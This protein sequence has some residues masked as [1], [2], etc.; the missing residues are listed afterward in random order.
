MARGILSFLFGRNSSAPAPAATLTPPPSSAR[1]H[2]GELAIREKNGIPDM[3][4]F[5]DR[6]PQHGTYDYSFT[7]GDGSGQFAFRA[8]PN[9]RTYDVYI[10]SQPGYGSRPAD[11]HATHRL[12]GGGDLRIC[13]KEGHAPRSIPEAIVTSLWWSKLTAKYIRDGRSWS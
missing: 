6:V 11:G 8:V 5:I 10:R 13:F 2:Q 1:L 4:Q 9:G 12:G 3:Q 7:L